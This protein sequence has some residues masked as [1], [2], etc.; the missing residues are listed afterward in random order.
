MGSLF[1]L[2]LLGLSIYLVCKA[3]NEERV[4]FG[5]CG[6]FTFV[7]FFPASFLLYPAT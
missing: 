3:V 7:S 4:D 2:V 1:L 6:I 5:L